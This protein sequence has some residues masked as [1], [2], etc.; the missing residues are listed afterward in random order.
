MTLKAHVPGQHDHG[1]VAEAER[2]EHAALDA[3]DEALH[4]ML[5]PTAT[6]LV[7]AQQSALHDA[8]DRIRAVDMGYS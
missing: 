2:G 6:E 8:V 4:G 1:I 3:Y 5:P 7:E